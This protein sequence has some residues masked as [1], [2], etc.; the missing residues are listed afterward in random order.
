MRKSSLI[1]TVLLGLALSFN[2]T[3]SVPSTA[4][5]GKQQITAG[6][7]TWALTAPGKMSIYT[8]FSSQAV[9][10]VYT[11]GYDSD[12]VVLR[13]NMGEVLVGANKTYLCWLGVGESAT[14]EL[15]SS[16]FY[17]GA[18]GALAILP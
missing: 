16:N 8:N 4:V 12:P 17:R 15:L 6:N 18:T 7:F 3:A 11:V 5:T 10:V 9:S 1:S 2:A 14:I 13:C